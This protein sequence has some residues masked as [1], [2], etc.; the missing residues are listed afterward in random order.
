MTEQIRFME[1]DDDTVVFVSIKGDEP[2][3]ATVLNCETEAGTSFPTVAFPA[4]GYTVPVVFLVHPPAGSIF[5][6]ELAD[7]SMGQ[8]F[9]RP[10]RRQLAG[11][12]QELCARKGWALDDHVTLN[13][14]Y[15]LEKNGITHVHNGNLAAAMDVVQALRFAC[16]RYLDVLCETQSDATT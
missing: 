7:F 10:Y 11:F 12:Y 16:Y 9:N 5:R 14:V 1:A 6:F 3:L 15:Y 13:I 2:L 8:F 4:H